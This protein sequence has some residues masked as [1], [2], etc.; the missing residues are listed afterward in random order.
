MASSVFNIA[1]VFLNSASAI[2]IE[3]AEVV[4]N[5]LV[6]DSTNNSVVRSYTSLYFL[7]HAAAHNGGES[8]NILILNLSLTVTLGRLKEK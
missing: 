5:V 1:D 8:F 7:L 4:K 3:M 2:N 6:S